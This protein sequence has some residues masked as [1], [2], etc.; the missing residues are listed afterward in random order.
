M[1]KNAGVSTGMMLLA[2]AIC[3]AAMWPPAVLAQDVPTVDVES[4]PLSANL[5]RLM[6]ALEYLGSRLD[7]STISAVKRAIRARDAD[8]MQAAI[9]KHVLLVVTINPE[10]R[11][12]VT[13]GG[14]EAVLQQG[15]YRPVLVKVLN[16]STI[17]KQLS[18][19]SPQAGPVYAGVSKLSMQRQQQEN[20]RQNEN[21]DQDP[22]RFLAAEMFRSPPMT[23]SL[24]GLEAE[25]AIAL[26]YSSQSGKREATLEFD[27]GQGSQ[28][29]GFRGETPVLFR[30]RPAV[31]VRLSIRD[32]DGSPAIAKLTFL[33]K[34]GHVYPPQ[35]KR[36]APDFFFQP[37]I[38]RND[39]E[40]VY[41]PPGEFEVTYSRGPEY[42]VRKTTLKV[43]D[44]PEQR[45]ELRL[46]RWISA[47]NYGFFSG[48]HHIH[49]AG[50]AHYTSP[51]EGVLPADMFRQIKGEGLNV[52]CVL[53]WGPCFDYQRQFFAPKS[54][55]IS[56]AMTVLKYDLEIS[57]FGS[58][59]LGHVCLLNLKNQ[60]Y[61]GSTSTDGW[62]TWTTPVLRWAKNQGGVVG[63]AHSA[64]GLQIVPSSAARW[65]LSQADADTDKQ[66][67]ELEASRVVLP[68][69]F[70]RIDGDKN[71]QLDQD[72]LIMA[73]DRAADELPNFAIPEMNGVGAME[74]CVAVSEGVCDFISTMDT[75]RIPEWNCWY[76]LM[77]CGFP[78]KVSG[79]TDFPCMSSRRVGQGRVYVQLGSVKRVDFTEWCY[80]LRDGRSYVSDGYAHATKFTVNGVAPGY[81]DVDLQCEGMVQ[82]EAQ[83]AFA[84]E[85]PRAIAHGTAAAGEGRRVSGDTR[86]LHGKRLDGDV[87]GGDRLIE[88]I[89]NGQVAATRN[90]PADGNVHSL[91]LQLP[92]ERSSWV[93]LR[94]FPQL[95]TNPVRVMVAGQPIRASVESARWCSEMTKRLWKNRKKRIDKSEREA[96]Q[97]AFE[98][99]WE[100]FAKIAD[101]AAKQTRSEK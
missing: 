101:E 26:I 97:A 57:G 43:Q 40:V 20:L 79:E 59:A 100:K 90:I 17:T 65:T 2:L 29:L 24:S 70:E 38:Y 85:T 50:C 72:E 86:I 34:L 58:Q 45:L 37:Y 77:N 13:R 61:P 53:T 84:P 56:E 48:D 89:V 99:T 54:L 5:R 75:E 74:I 41:L 44:L 68:F 96:A 25:Y 3:G 92:I 60:H 30:V 88:I 4:Q 10:S 9:D 16:Q 80:A 71:G 32:Q 63:Y 6:E 42:V 51:T 35:A 62:P 12:K 1:N 27:V 83:V 67:S 49:A 46:K 82:L 18:I 28:D 7:E 14:A 98:R 66:L 36:L 11:V 33:D 87:A 78:L 19:S 94:Q 64:S 91:K 52:G 69:T 31:P 93:A 39:A 8:A 95:H 21:I 47:A 23:E 81:G 76:H 73:A 15:G 22:D 55:N